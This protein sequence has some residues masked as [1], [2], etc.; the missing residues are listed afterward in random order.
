[1]RAKIQFLSTSFLLIF[2]GLLFSAVPTD[3]FR[4]VIFRLPTDQR[5]G[6]R[7]ECSRPN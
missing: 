6:N 5:G 4:I 1:M 7:S 3:F 2:L